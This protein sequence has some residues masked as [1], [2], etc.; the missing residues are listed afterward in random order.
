LAGLSESGGTN[1]LVNIEEPMDGTWTVLVYGYLVPPGGVAYDMWT[2]TVPNSS[3]GSLSV[4]GAPATA[5]IGETG[6]IDF[7]WSGLA[8]GTSSDWY[9]GGISHT[10]DAGLLDVTVVNIDNR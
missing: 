4:D 8:A 2:W 3:G 9:L 5:V 6:T 1:E 10:G 7:S